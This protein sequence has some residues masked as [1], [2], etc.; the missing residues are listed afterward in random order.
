MSESASFQLLHPDVQKWVWKQNW[1]KLRDIQEQAIPPILEANTDV[2]ISASTAGGKT[3]A[4]FLPACSRIAT[5]KPH[6][7]SVLYVSPLKALINDQ[8]RRLEGLCDILDVPITIWHGDANQASKNKLQKKPEG[9]L[10][11][12]PE[13]LEAMLIRRRGWCIRAFSAL[14]HIII[15]EFHAFLGTERG[16]QL[17]S[18]L[19]RLEFMLERRV[20]RIALSATLGEMDKVVSFLRPK[21]QN[22][23]SIQIESR[24][25]TTDLRVQLKGYIERNRS[26]DMY[27]SAL[28][29]ISADLYNL[30]RGQSNL[31]FA[32]SRTRTEAMA[33]ALAER[34]GEEGVP[35]EFFPHHGSLSKE[36]REDVEAR[37]LRGSLP[38]SAICTVTLEL[39]IDIGS[40]H[41][42]AQ[43]L[44]PHSVASLRQRLGRSGRR[45]EA[46]ILRMFVIESEK[47][48]DTHVGDRL[49]TQTVQ[50]IA[51]INL[52]LSKWCEP[53]SDDTYH[54]STLVQ[55]T[56][57]VIGQ[58]GGVRADQ[59][60]KLLCDG[61][62]F[63]NVDGQM[64]AQLLRSLGE[65][66][67]IT[68]MHDGLITL[69]KAGETMVSHYKFYS[70]FKTPEEYKLECAGKTLGSIPIDWP[71]QK[72]QHIVFAGKRW[73]VLSI[74]TEDMIVV[75]RRSTGGVP[76]RFYGQG[77]LLHERVRAEMYQV[78]VD[79]TIPPYLDKRAQE[80]LRQGI[81]NFHAY[82]LAKT[83]FVQRDGNLIIFV[84]KG[85]RT[86][87][88]IRELLVR[89]GLAANCFGAHIEVLNCTMDM[90]RQAVRDTLS[91]PP[92]TATELSQTVLDTKTEK[93]DE[94]VPDGLRNACY[95][96]KNFDVSGAIA[97]LSD[98]KR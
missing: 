20:S 32:N 83:S 66:D 42:I 70:A 69:G 73:E 36:L 26:D 43:I 4:A 85:D 75:L 81:A 19:H 3:E 59:L 60:W 54:L 25:I 18:L 77:G 80:N 57:A 89:A 61:G 30:L 6:T 68:Q 53:P 50:C 97:W 31:I 35:N 23:P 78:Y 90:Y 93:F 48:K 74:N 62:P 58:Y 56:L 11:I 16:R 87:L 55:Q 88:A 15:D 13:S 37:L 76:P 65:H 84:W 41:S 24:E 33:V 38:T 40:V 64:Y 8:H 82:G 22:Y 79:Q 52:L 67:L 98:H 17:Q 28:Q 49:C 9:I 10:L 27:S 14:N 45:G 29:E 12:T 71:L 91:Q 39:G 2:I 94:Y 1:N 96:G 72:G 95:G 86:S 63:N 5:Q 21:T 44:A 92:P 47:T 46:A 34:C 51:M 7:I